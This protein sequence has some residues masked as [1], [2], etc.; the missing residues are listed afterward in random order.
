LILIHLMPP[1]VLLILL[2]M[3]GFA[4]NIESVNEQ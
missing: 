4:C 1:F 3:K 2:I